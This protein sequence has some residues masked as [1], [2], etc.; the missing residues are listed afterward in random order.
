M[1]TKVVFI[2]DVS[3]ALRDYMK[4]HLADSQVELIYPEVFKQ[5]EYQKLAKEADIIVGWKMTKEILDNAEKLKLWIN[6]GAGVHHLLD[7]YRD[8]PRFEQFEVVNGHGNAFQTAEHL[9]ALTYAL[10]NDLINH[11]GFMKDG[12]WRTGDKEGASYTLKHKRIGLMGYGHVNK[13]VHRLLSSVPVEFHV[14]KR[15]SKID[16]DLPYSKVYHPDQLKDFVLNTDLLIIALPHTKATEGLIGEAELGFLGNNGLIVN[17]G[18]GCIID[19]EALFM[20][21]KNKN[22]RGAA[23]DV[24]YNYKPE[25]VDGKKYPYSF[26]FHEL[27]NIILSPHRAASP[28]DVLDRWEDAVANIKAVVNNSELVNVVDAELEY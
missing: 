22:I 5:E 28:F 18:R 23:I 17:G 27:D 9:V 21:L 1:S 19:E 3:P 26:P 11:H 12:V 20:S 7:V 14:Y 25:E 10:A 6:P 4:D 15:S 8:H 2:W 24:W 16:T 13:E